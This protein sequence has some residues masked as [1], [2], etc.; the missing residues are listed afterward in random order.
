MP[1]SKASAT[2]VKLFYLSDALTRPL[3]DCLEWWAYGFFV[4]RIAT[5]SYDAIHEHVAT[6]IDLREL[7]QHLD[8]RFAQIDSRFGTFDAPL[9][10]SFESLDHR[11]TCM[12]NRLMRLT[13]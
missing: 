12:T 6:K 13:R 4:E 2:R 11:I 7:E 10:A 5:E 9:A 8:T 3:E 1:T